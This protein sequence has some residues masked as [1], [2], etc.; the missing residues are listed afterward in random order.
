MVEVAIGMQ[1]VGGHSCNISGVMENCNLTI[2]QFTGPVHLFVAAQAQ[3]CI[4]GQHFLFDYNCTLDYP[5]NS[6]FLTFPGNIGRRLTVPISKMGQG[7][8]WNQERH[9][10][11]K[12]AKIGKL[13]ETSQPFS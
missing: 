1:A 9:L 5:G 2:G 3:E 4:L 7:Q 12:S 6:K 8:G 13:Q 10:K 11:A